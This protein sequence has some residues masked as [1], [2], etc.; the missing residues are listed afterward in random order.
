M[1]KTVMELWTQQ[2]KQLLIRWILPQL[3]EQHRLPSNL[4]SPVQLEVRQTYMKSET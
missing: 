2:L 1:I 3:M 4:V